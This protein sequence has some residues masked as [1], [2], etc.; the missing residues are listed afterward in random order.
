[1]E[2]MRTNIFDRWLENYAIDRPALESKCVYAG[3]RRDI[4]VM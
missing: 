2:L 1:M 4:L 3:C